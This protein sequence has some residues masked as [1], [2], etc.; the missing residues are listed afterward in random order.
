ML[1]QIYDELFPKETWTKSQ[2][3]KY[4]ALNTLYTKEFWANYN[5]QPC[6]A[7]KAKLKDF[8]N[9][10]LIPPQDLGTRNFSQLN[11][12]LLINDQSIYNN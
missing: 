7:N 4:L 5:L 2:S 6:L 11:H 12:I 1:L 3:L 10:N 8:N 9:L